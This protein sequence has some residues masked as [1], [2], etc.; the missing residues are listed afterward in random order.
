MGNTAVA[1]T[2]PAAAGSSAASGKT[3]AAPKG[4]ETPPVK[5]PA[6][7][8]A[9]PAPA[10]G[11]KAAPPPEP[12]KAPEAGKGETEEPVSLLDE[13]TKPAAETP[14]AAVVPDKY[15]FKFSEGSFL[16]QAEADLI[17]ANARER[18]LSGEQ[19][20][21]ELDRAEGIVK[22]YQDRQVKAY[23]ASLAKYANE[24]KTHPEFGGERF[25]DNLKEAQ[26]AYHRFA[27]PGFKK[28][29]KELGAD[30]HVEVL[31]TFQAIN[32]A[33]SDDKLVSGQVPPGVPK[34][35]LE[36]IYKVPGAEGNDE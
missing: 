8:P 33:M 30:N 35:G 31:L 11:S 17:A 2:T 24:A 7:A 28:L 18:K 10:A 26:A 4:T 32:K 3:E 16:S 21:A 20:Q 12:T 34:K 6:A 15:E 29:A 14:A 36:G 9:A 1:P 27:T 13:G 19:A 25:K 5:A 22:A 23:K